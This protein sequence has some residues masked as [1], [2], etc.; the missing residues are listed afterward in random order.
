MSIMNEKKQKEIIC[1]LTGDTINYGLGI[2]ATI[3]R[4]AWPTNKEK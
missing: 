2:R 1:D 4:Y 3:V